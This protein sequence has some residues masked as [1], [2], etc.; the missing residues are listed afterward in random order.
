MAFEITPLALEETPL[1]YSNPEKDKEFGCISHLR[2]D[3]G[4]KGREFWHSWFDHQAELNTPEFKADIASV[5]ECLRQDLLKNYGSMANYCYQH[6]ETRIQGALYPETYGFKLHTGNYC[7]YIRCSLQTGDY[8]FYVYCFKNEND[9]QYE[10][11]N[12]K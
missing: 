3:F 5:M 11:T 12:G 1:F 6:G 10:R 7:Y 8:N 9:R 2:G 4:H